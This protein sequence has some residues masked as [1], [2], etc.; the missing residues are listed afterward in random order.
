MRG[1]AACV[2]AAMLGSGITLWVVEHDG[3]RQPGVSAQESRG[4]LSAPPAVFPR[5]GIRAASFPVTAYNVD[6]LTPDEAISSSVYEWCNRS[7]VNISTIS[8]RSDRF[9]MSVPEE[10]NGSGAVLDKQG[11]ILT[12]YHVVQGA[13]NMSV[14]LFNEETYPAKLVGR[15]PVND[16]AVIKIDAPAEMLHP[17]EL[18]TSDDLRVGMR[19]FA[20]GNPFGLERTMSQGIISS[21]N[22]TLE[23]QRDWVIKSIIQIDCSIN[24]GN[25]GG[26]LIDSHGR[27]IGMNTAIA[28]RVEQSAG[29]GFAIPVNLIRRVI[30]ELIEHGRVI[31]GDIGITHVTVIDKGLRVARLTPGGPAEKAG[32]RGP[33]TTRRGPLVIIDRAKAD[34][35]TAVDRQPVTNAAEFLGIIENKKPGDVISVTLLR[36][37][38]TVNVNVTL[39]TDASAPTAENQ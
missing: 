25:S 32:I 38:E 26:P 37:A 20:V 9:F 17:V 11:H 6:G 8:V 1:F 19:V 2:L 35:I 22:R 16:L 23:V 4:G 12:N 7:V 13:R 34:V 28:S 10:G 14:A 24:P 15:D 3:F 33:E 31:R 36:G 21:L 29:I 27:M 5:S 18:G 39:V 30:P